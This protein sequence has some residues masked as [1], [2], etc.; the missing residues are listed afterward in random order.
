V[1]DN[2]AVVMATRELVPEE[3]AQAIPLHLAREGYIGMNGEQL[4]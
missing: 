2:A 4:P 3:A 1:P